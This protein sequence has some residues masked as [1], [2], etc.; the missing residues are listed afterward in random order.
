MKSIRP[1]LKN[2]VLARLVLP[3]MGADPR[4]QHGEL[5]RL[6]HIV[7]GAG[8][9]PEHR[10]G[11]GALRRQHHH[12]AL[13]AVLAHHLDRLAAIHVG[14]ADIH[15]GEIDA[16]A[17]H[18]LDGRRRGIGRRKPELLV[19]GELLGQ[20]VAQGLVVIDQQDMMDGG[21]GWGS[22]E[23]RDCGNMSLLS[24]HRK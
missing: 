12:R 16:V 22:L 20:R 15:D 1:N 23:R 11:V 24:R 17:L 7:V 2:G 14:Q 18:G 5:E 13:E 21:H 6:D 9:E 4:Q 10:I 8:L 19:Q 3:K